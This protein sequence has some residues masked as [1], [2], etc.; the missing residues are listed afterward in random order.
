MTTANT[1]PNK[2]YHCR[3]SEDGGFNFGERERVYFKQFMKSNPGML[4]KIIPVLPESKKQRKMFEGAFVPLVTYYQE[5]LDHTSTEDLE[6]VRW[7]LKKEF[8]G[9]MVEI[10]GKVEKVPKSTKGRDVLQP[11]MERVLNWIIEQYSPPPEALEP[12]K[13]KYWKDAIRPY[14]GAD[15]YIDYLKE[16]K[17]L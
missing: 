3:I 11:F 13:Y 10:G 6:R 1:K 8:N 5:G 2:E 12:S 14:G 17:I 4:L 15:N 7:W 9:E 16:L